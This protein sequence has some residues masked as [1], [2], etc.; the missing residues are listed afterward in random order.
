MKTELL[1]IENCVL[2]LSK[3]VFLQLHVTSGST[4]WT[5]Y[6]VLPIICLKNWKFYIL[7]F[8]P[9]KLYI[10]KGNRRVFKV[11]MNWKYKTWSFFVPRHVFLILSK[12][13]YNFYIFQWKIFSFLCSILSFKYDG[14]LVTSESVVTSVDILFTLLSSIYTITVSS[15]IVL[16][17]KMSY[18]L[19]AFQ[20]WRWW[21]LCVKNYFRAR[22]RYIKTNS[23]LLNQTGT[24]KRNKRGRWSFSRHSRVRIWSRSCRR[25]LVSKCIISCDNRALFYG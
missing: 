15:H 16:P 23:K 19:G 7:T 12:K 5:T 6:Q 20:N 8:V 4:I 3:T 22:Q 1:D 13:K 21:L 2:Y 9:Q 18:P 17:L 24:Q 11:N 14:S 25:W 10:D